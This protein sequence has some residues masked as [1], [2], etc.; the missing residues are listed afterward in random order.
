MKR[1]ASLLLCVT[2]VTVFTCSPAFAD[3][4]FGKI[5]YKDG[6]KAG[7]EVG[8]STSWNSKKAYP[9][10]GSYELDF[11][12]TVGREINIFVKGTKVG[13]VTVKGS[14]RFDITIP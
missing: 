10:N 4:L 12:E 7:G 8:V 6:S 5:V 11:G 14:T 13:S 1:F 2:L 9:K 3:K